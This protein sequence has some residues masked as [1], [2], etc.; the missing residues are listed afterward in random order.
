MKKN[1]GSTDVSIRFILAICCF[2]LTATK[3]LV[4]TWATATII[5]GVYL[6][7]TSMTSFCPLYFLLRVSTNR[8]KE[9]DQEI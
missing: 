3:V 5:A 1:A 4:G 9:E 2:I 7:V 6:I 8:K